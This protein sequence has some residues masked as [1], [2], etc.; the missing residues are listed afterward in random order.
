[1]TENKLIMIDNIDVSKCKYFVENNG[2]YH[3]GLYQYTNMC[4]KLPY[5]NC[6]NKRFC[7]HKIISKIRRMFKWIINQ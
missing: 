3:Q 6:E 2:V 7:W 5:D 1:M 4:F